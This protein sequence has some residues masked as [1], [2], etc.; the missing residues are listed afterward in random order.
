MTEQEQ[1]KYFLYSV[2]AGKRVSSYYANQAAADGD[3]LELDPDKMLFAVGA[4]TFYGERAI[5]T[6]P[7]GLILGDGGMFN[8]KAS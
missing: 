1:I 4:A 7:S 5:M 2:N 8:V 3:C 6:E